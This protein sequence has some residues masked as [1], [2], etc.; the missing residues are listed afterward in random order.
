MATT[1]YSFSG[2]LT[3]RCKLYIRSSV[4][5]ACHELTKRLD[6]NNNVGFI[7][8]TTFVHVPYATFWTILG[9]RLNFVLVTVCESSRSRE[10]KT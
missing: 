3:A 2:W 7:S 9:P 1:D 5:S 4:L 10:S 6:S 8:A